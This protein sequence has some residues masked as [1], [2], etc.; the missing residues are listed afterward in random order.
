MTYSTEIRDYENI[1]DEKDFN[2]VFDWKGKIVLLT[3]ARQWGKDHVLTWGIYNRHLLFLSNEI[4]AVLR[5]AIK[6]F[7][8]EGW[9]KFPDTWQKSEDVELKITF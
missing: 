4:M 8:Y 6:T 3:M 9:S 1:N 2:F 5:D 7:K